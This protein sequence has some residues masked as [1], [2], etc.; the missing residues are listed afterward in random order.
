[1]ELSL[2]AQTINNTF[3]KL[4]SPNSL[5]RF[6]LIKGFKPLRCLEISSGRAIREAKILRKNSIKDLNMLKLVLYS[7][8]PP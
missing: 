7:L 5:R 6:H 2:N 1:M 4:P 3:P 8:E